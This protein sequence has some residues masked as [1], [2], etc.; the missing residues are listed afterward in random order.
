MATRWA[1]RA[2][3]L[4]CAVAGGLVV[5]VTDARGLGGLGNAR[6]EG[7]VTAPSAAASA[8]GG[9]ADATK[10]L[11]G[12]SA[13]GNENTEP[14]RLAFGGDV[15]FEGALSAALAT[16]PAGML[17][18]IAPVLQS[19]DLAMV[20]LETAITTGGTPAPKQYNFRAPPTGL[21]ALRSAGVDVVSMAN[22]HGLD[23][24]VAGLA[25]S[26][27]AEAATGFPVI[28][29]G[30]DEAEAYA[31]YTATVRGQTVAFI[32]ATQ[33]LDGALIA[34][35]TAGP[36]Q[37]GLASAKRV[38]RL[39]SEVRAA[40]ETADIVVVYLHWGVETASC[41]SGDQ[42]QLAR[43]LVDAGA[44]VIVG[45]HAHRLQGAGRMDAAL[46]AYGLG[47]FAFYANG[48]LGAR[49]G[50]LTVTVGGGKEV[51]YQWTPAV[52]RGGVPHPLAGSEAGRAVEDF[53]ALRECT[54]LQR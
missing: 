14:I 47:N 16:D 20:N 3:L 35:W 8:G 15:H 54:D 26:L 31:P 17:A 7:V 38:D 27:A 12:K 10:A 4:A 34:S 33:V 39:V 30:H 21:E 19:A 51:D 36:A 46:V 52:I 9:D 25:D 11:T 53:E 42:Q 13:S 32:G 18:P 49:S 40:G 23:F 29:I 43:R 24:G 1:F 41:P 22:N 28:G 6:A 37:P 2:Q 5:L 45:T 50:V 48:G 44:D